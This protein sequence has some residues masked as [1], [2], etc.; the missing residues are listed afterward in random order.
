MQVILCLATYSLHEAVH[1][2][3]PDQSRAISTALRVTRVARGPCLFLRI[4]SW[5]WQSGPHQYVPQV[6]GSPIGR[7]D[8]L[9]VEIPRGTRVPQDVS[10]V[11]DNPL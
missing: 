8:L 11:L 2:T 5:L 1:F 6:L 4:T 9:V 10:I 3:L 7:N